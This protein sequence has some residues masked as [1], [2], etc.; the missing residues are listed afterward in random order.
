MVIGGRS[1]PVV[2]S[3]IPEVKVVILNT[4][5]QVDLCIYKNFNLTVNRK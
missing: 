4:S 2:L 5:P 3:S 1:S